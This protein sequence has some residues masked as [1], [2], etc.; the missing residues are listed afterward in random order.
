MNSTEIRKHNR[1]TAQDFVCDALMVACIV[2][3]ACGVLELVGSF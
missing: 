1:Y 3:A 2:A